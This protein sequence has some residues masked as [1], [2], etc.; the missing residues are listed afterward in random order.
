[1]KN[2]ITKLNKYRIMSKMK[3][4]FLLVLIFQLIIQ[5]ISAQ[6]FEFRINPS[7]NLTYVPDFNNLIIIVNDG[8]IVP[9]LISPANSLT[10][11]LESESISKTNAKIGFSLDLEFVVK[12]SDKLQLSISSGFNQLRFNYDTYVEAEGTQSV[13][14]SDLSKDYGYTNLLYINLKPSNISLDLFNSRFK[15]QCGPTFNFLVKS[16]YNNVLILYTSEQLDGTTHE[17]VDKVYFESIGE[18]NKILYGAHF[19]TAFNIIRQF[20]IFISGQYYFN[21]IYFAE[22]NGYQTLTDCK[23]FQIQAGV[24]YVIWNSGNKK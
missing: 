22:D 14:L 17:Y 23:P 2:R 11:P 10:P 16:N 15:I 9:G 19:R 4:A 3:H 5:S 1:M 13:N 6:E 21:S 24:S 12:L 8:L 7:T 20:D 18:M